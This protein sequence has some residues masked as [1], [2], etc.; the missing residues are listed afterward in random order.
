[1]ISMVQ[2]VRGRISFPTLV[3]LDLLFPPVVSA[4]GKAQAELSLPCPCHNMATMGLDA[5][6]SCIQGW[7]T[8]SLTSR[9]SCPV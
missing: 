5:P 3:T 1:M 2:L 8:C 9:D 6:L 4:R 7:L